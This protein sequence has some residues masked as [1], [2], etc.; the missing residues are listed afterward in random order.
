MLL[1]NKTTKLF[2]AYI[3]CEN[4]EI[5][6]ESGKCINLIY[7]TENKKR[8]YIGYFKIIEDAKKRDKLRRKNYLE[9]S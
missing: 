6:L 8:F 5:E 9:N 4:G 3:L 1:L 7:Y 2:E